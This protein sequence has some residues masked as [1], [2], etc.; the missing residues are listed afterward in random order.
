MA[1]LC[2]DEGKNNVTLFLSGMKLQVGENLYQLRRGVFVHML[3]KRVFSTYQHTVKGE[4]AN[5][6][7]SS[8]EALLWLKLDVTNK[9][10]SL[11]SSR[12]SLVS[13]EACVIPVE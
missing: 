11:F 4:L 3:N 2:W 8:M 6:Q 12:T 9:P 5:Q 10:K 7:R 13:S 1:E